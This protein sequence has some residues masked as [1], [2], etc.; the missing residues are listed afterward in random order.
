MYFSV[1]LPFL[2]LFLSVSSYEYEDGEFNGAVI[3][4]FSHFQQSL[5]R[6]VNVGVRSMCLLLYVPNTLSF[7]LVS[8][9]EFSGKL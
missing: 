7:L 3:G 6:T 2:L 5:F 8:N 9:S 1:T 4:K